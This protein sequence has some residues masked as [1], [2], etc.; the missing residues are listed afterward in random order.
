ML[1]QVEQIGTRDR[2]LGAAM[3]LFSE[4]GYLSTSVADLLK[5][6]G[7]NSGSLYHFFATKQDVLLA[8]LESYRD[9]IDAMLIEP[10]W[11]GVDDPIDRVF[12]LLAVYR[13]LLVETDCSYGCPI[14]SLALELHEPDPPVRE[15]LMANFAAWQQRIASCF[16]QAGDRF[17]D[18]M[19]PEA[20]ATYVLT[21]M[22]GGVMLSRTFRSLDAFDVSVASLKDHIDRLQTDATHRKRNR[23]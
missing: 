21:I 5:T 9:G 19:D 6:A 12:A 14:G 10:A 20:L 22:E 8:V 15:L 7:V 1:N 23:K 17:A 18:D 4:K 11:S 3:M 16:A 13:Q 2:I